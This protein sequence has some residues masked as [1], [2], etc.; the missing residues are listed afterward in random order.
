MA[1]SGFS[2]LDGNA[3]VLM[4][5][6][7]LVYD[8]LT[9]HGVRWRVYHEGIPFFTLMARWIPEILTSSI[10]PDSHFRPLNQLVVD[11][12]D[13]DAATFPQVIFVE[14]KYTD[15]PP[16]GHGR[17]DHPPSAISGG[18]GF[19]W[20]VYLAI[21]SDPTRWGRTAMV[22]TYDEH[23]GFF[24]HVQPLQVVTNPPAGASY[25]P[26][27]TSG[28]RVPT[29]VASPLVPAG[30]VFSDNFDHTSILKFLGDKFNQGSYS[31]VVDDRAAVGSL[32]RVFAQ[33]IV[34][35]DIPMPPPPTGLPPQPSPQVLAF[36]AAAQ[37]AYTQDSDASRK[38][39]PDSWNV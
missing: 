31:P 39:I 24:D 1:M 30:G 7:E 8:W 9:Q 21:T 3:S 35:T 28:L 13:E 36:Q 15:A 5:P 20:E 38:A 4:P 17:D 27:I 19:L 33:P 6:Q 22:V 16:A 10:A 32:S 37:A 14:P 29:L 23:G 26:F 2:M 25:T 18:Q 34:R 12:Q 11:V